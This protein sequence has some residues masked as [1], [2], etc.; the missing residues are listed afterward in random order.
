VSDFDRIAQHLALWHGYDSAV[1][2]ELYSTCLITPDGSYLI[3][4]ILLEN[5]L[6]FDV[7]P[8]GRSWY[9]EPNVISNAVGYANFSVAHMML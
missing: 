6:I 2:V 3:D 7:P 9:G 1:K 4:P 8:F 5:D